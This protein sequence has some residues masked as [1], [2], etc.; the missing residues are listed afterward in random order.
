MTPE[1]EI[2]DTDGETADADC[3]KCD[4]STRS[5]RCQSCEDGFSE[6]DHDCGEDTCCCLDP[7]P[8]ECSECAGKGWFHWC[9]TCGWDLIEKCY[10]NGRDE[11]SG[12]G[13]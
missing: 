9:P 10:L 8:G 7:E 11:R 2:D 4:G 13:A 1:I 5:R 6:S 12:V 3:P